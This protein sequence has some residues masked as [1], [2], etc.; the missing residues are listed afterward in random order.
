MVIPVSRLGDWS[1]DG[2]S[3]K[4]YINSLIQTSPPA[5]SFISQPLQL[6]LF[7]FFCFSPSSSNSS[8]GRYIKP[9]RWKSLFHLLPFLLCLQQCLL[10]TSLWCNHTKD[11]TSSMGGRSMIST[12]TL[13]MVC[14]VLNFAFVSLSIIFREKGMGVGSWVKGLW[15]YTDLEGDVTY[16]S[17]ANASASQLAY[18]NSAGNAIIKVDNTTFVPYNEKRNSVST[19]FSSSRPEVPWCVCV[20]VCMCVLSN[21]KFAIASITAEWGCSDVSRGPCVA[22]GVRSQFGYTEDN[23]IRPIPATISRQL[24]PAASMPSL[25]HR[26]SFY[27]SWN[28]LP[29]VTLHYS[30]AL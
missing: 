30:T 8:P 23:N 11:K 24:V 4:E 7:L 17:Q 12:T 28:N 18:V 22:S 26:A 27:L 29:S 3:G 20:R 5:H 15:A 19:P 13:R 6:F 21:G 25:H 14:P 16:V 2:R 9:L 10:L 1:L